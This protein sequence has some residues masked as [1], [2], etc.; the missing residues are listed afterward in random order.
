[1]LRQLSGSKQQQQ[2]GGR[3]GTPDS[4]PAG[5]T[6]AEDHTIAA[7]LHKETQGLGDGQDAGDAFDTVKQLLAARNPAMLARLQS[8][9]EQLQE[10]GKQDEYSEAES[11]GSSD[12]GE[13]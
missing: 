13:G 6:D 2:Q 1:M 4:I 11:D 12:R 8:M 9:A 3:S 5:V 7:C 10:G